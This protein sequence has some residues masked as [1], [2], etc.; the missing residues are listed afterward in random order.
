MQEEMKQIAKRLAGLRDTFDTSVEALAKSID[1]PVDTYKQYESGKTDI[2]VGVLFRIAGHFGIELASILSGE[3]PKLKAFCLVRKGEG[4]SVERRTD[5]KYVSL[6]FNFVHKKAEPFLV[7]VEPANGDK[8]APKNFHP[9]QEF[10]YCIEGS[11][12]ISVDSHTMV[13]TEGDS[14]FFDSS[15]PHG[16]KALGGKR[17]RFIAVI[18]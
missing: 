3:D 6:A 4:M 7:T 17:A 5:Y 18:M 12:E 16:M 11:L 10:D 8:P 15:L 9:G 13:L 14:V 1:V 2:P